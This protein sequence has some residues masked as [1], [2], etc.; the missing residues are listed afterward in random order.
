MYPTIPAAIP[1]A[2]PPPPPPPPPP[3]TSAVAPTTQVM[4]PVIAVPTPGG[5]I[6]L[7]LQQLQSLLTANQAKT[8][9]HPPGTKPAYPCMWNTC[10]ESFDDTAELSSHITRSNHIF[11]E[12]D[13]NYYCYWSHCSRNKSL[14]GKP[15]DTLQKITRHVKEVHLLRIHTQPAPVLKSLPQPTIPVPLIKDI[16][17]TNTPPSIPIPAVNVTP[18]PTTNSLTH[19]HES[20]S[21]IPRSNIATTSVPVTPALTVTPQQAVTT[22]S[23]AV[24]QNVPHSDSLPS[25][26]VAPPPKR[27]QIYHSKLYLK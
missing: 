26:F 16:N 14:G 22:A 13:G 15:F 17:S 23:S 18:T 10:Q 11:P 21:S 3:V 9:Q 24:A 20:S 1:V 25:I 8:V 12:S 27:K 4:T 7:S 6:T 5:H 2:T 19:F